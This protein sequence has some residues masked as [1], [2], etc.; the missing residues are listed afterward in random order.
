MTIGY[1]YF[2][3]KWYTSALAMIS[4]HGGAAGGLKNMTHP[5]SVKCSVQ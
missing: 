1:Q 4:L 2:C 5:H 3:S